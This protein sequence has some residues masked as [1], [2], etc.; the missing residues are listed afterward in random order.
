MERL[1]DGDIEASWR[2]ARLAM[3]LIVAANAKQGTL[4]QA[5]VDFCLG[6]G[7]EPVAQEPASQPVV[8]RPERPDTPAVTPAWE[9]PPH[10][11]YRCSEPPTELDPSI[12]P[13]G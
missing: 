1:H 8:L 6:L 2:E 3:G 10:L 7:A 11:P 9:W 13:H 5:E 4:Q 12:D